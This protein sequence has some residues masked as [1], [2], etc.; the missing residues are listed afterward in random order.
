MLVGLAA[1][2]AV[3]AP[4]AAQAPSPDALAATAHERWG[5]I[6]TYCVECHNFEDWAGG[7][8]F[9][10]MSPDGVVADAEIWEHALTKLRG[11][12]MPPPG[13]PQPEQAQIDGFVH[14]LEASIDS[15]ARDDGPRTGHVQIQR[16]NATEYAAAVKSLLGV[17]MD[18]K[19]ILPTEVEVEGFDN[20]ATALMISPAF[21]EQYISAGRRAAALAVGDP[22]A[23]VQFAF[24]QPGPGSRT[25]H[26][27]G[28][29]LGTRGGM[30][31]THNFPADGEYRFTVRDLGVGL[32]PRPTETNHTLVLLIDGREV[33]RADIGGKEDLEIADLT[34]AAGVV[35]LMEPFTDIPIQ[36]SAGEHEVTATFIQRARASS[37]YPNRGGGFG[38]NAG[39]G[40]S[41]GG[42]SLPAVG[43]GIDVKGP[44]TVTGMTMT[45]S[46]Q[47]VFVCYPE[48]AAEEAPCAEEIVSNLA[49]R[50]YRRPVTDADLAL[51]MPF[52]ESARAS[53]ASFDA[54]IRDAVTAVLANPNFLFRAITPPAESA[55]SAYALSDLEL[56][57]RLAFFLW[58][59]GPDEEL[60]EVAERGGL[61]DTATLDAQVRRML[62]DPRAETL[63]TSFALKWLN[64]D[65]L[66][67]VIPDGDLFPAFND[68]L[69]ADFEIETKLF[70]DSVL[71]EDQSIM[72]LLDADYTFVNESLARHYGILGVRGDQFR[73][74]TLQDPNRFGIIGKG[75][76]LLRTSYGDRTSPVLRG[77]WVMDKLLGTPPSPPPPGVETDLSIHEGELPTTVRARLEEHRADQNCNACHGV[78]DPWGLALENYDVIG[79][80]RTEDPVARSPIDANTVLAG[81][82]AINGPA[83]LREQLMERPELIAENFTEKLMMYALGREVEHTDMPQVRAIARAAAAEDYRLS[84]IVL[85]IVNSDAFRLQ[86]NIQ[87][88]SLADGMTG[89]E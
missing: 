45:P 14:W 17:D 22:D 77:A 44:Y 28:M 89:G 65:D 4:A 59:Q 48:T 58:S 53:G 60:L 34:G 70:L 30:S 49:R 16:L 86:S 36:V 12:L 83:E 51:L 79:R 42:M 1:L 20:I 72:R 67:A 29:P 81:G 32:Y 23:Q 19:T 46:R 64:L 2:A 73:R 63:V 11:R 7:V 57:S 3:A 6:E 40:I 76:M 15:A 43:G 31:F 47:L 5:M 54:G 75:A 82:A 18:P 78:I 74:V 39:Q 24:Y 27:D 8:A 21:L 55:D 25:E 85:G 61:S 71:L 41:A 80:W 33:Y 26:V 62:A 66:D 9:D 10:T 69:R 52:Y 88:A 13:E 56:A 68:G 87:A 37:E 38:N 84:A 50:A 35:T